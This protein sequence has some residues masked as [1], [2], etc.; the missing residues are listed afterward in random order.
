MAAIL[1]EEHIPLFS[2]ES[3]RP[4]RD[5]ELLG[6]SL[7]YELTYSNILA[8]LSL[9]AIP[10]RAAGRGLQEPLIVG[11]GPCAFNPEPLAEFFDFFFLG[12]A[13]EGL[14]EV[15]TVIGRARTQ[16]TSKA[17]LLHQLCSIEGVY[18]PAFYQ[19]SYT[20]DGRIAGIARESGVPWPVRKRIVTDF[21]R[22]GSP[23]C[24]VVP[25]QE[26]VH[27][28][29]MLEIMRGCTH[30]CRFCQAGM[31]YRPV[32]ERPMQAIVEQMA[33]LVPAT[34]FEE[35]S[36]T[37]LSSTD[38]GQIG[39]LFKAL[40]DQ[41]GPRGIGIS[42]PSLRAD[43][44]SVDLA[45]RMQGSRK[46]SLTFAPEAGSQRLRQVINKDLTEE[47]I[48]ATAEAVF[49]AGWQR[50]KLYFMIGLPTETRGDLA[51]LAGL[52]RRIME[53]GRR[54][55]S[56]A[57]IVVSI[58]TFV[59]KAHTPFQW[60]PQLD[61]AEIESRQAFLRDLIRGRGLELQWHQ[62]E[63]SLLEGVFARGDRRL[64]RV[65][66]AAHEL[67]CCFDG[68]SEWFSFAKWHEAFVACD[69]D[70]S[71]YA[72][73]VR[74]CDEILPWD[75]LSAGVTKEFLAAEDQQAQ[76]GLVTRDCRSGTCAG[77]GVC[78]ALGLAAPRGERA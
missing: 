12:E 24:F 33:R 44:F 7:Q 36:L 47:D 22:A 39:E 13:E 67:G 62:A 63:Q 23:W 58:S 32:R 76:R 19:V 1:R 65:L 45:A 69:V 15:L 54:R 52:V 78:T 26:I 48:L 2:L 30:G 38:H 43:R 37:S 34:G 53:I 40:Q 56:R 3:W 11:G 61:L 77:C 59:P 10:L 49:T 25:H 57:H 17:C 70:P 9:A 55:T 64:A 18:V 29:G 27:D 50:L 4:L 20:A 42:L 73:R 72:Q 31:V 46:T 21:E 71:F 75:H 74:D 35:V 14:R 60:R 5:F 6:F 51:D 16:G 68:W 8:M 41:Y 66:S 28:R